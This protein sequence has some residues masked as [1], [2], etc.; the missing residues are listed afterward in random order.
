LSYD[1]HYNTEYEYMIRHITPHIGSDVA[2]PK[3]LRGI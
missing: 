2:L 3:T 1:I